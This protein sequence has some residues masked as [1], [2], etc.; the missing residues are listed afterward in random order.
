MIVQCS[1]LVSLTFDETIA[2]H[3]KVV[4]SSF[5]WGQL[6]IVFQ[7]LDKRCRHN[8]GYMSIKLSKDL[9]MLDS[10]PKLKKESTTD[11]H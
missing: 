4:L 9:S 11:A 1:A 2:P 10:I 3:L 6:G 8:I 7:Y 5:R